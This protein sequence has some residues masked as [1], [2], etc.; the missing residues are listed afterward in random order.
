LEKIEKAKKAGFTRWFLSYT[1]TQKDVEQFRELVGPDAEVVLKIE[2]LKGIH[3]ALF[4][5][6]KD[7]RT[8]LMAAMGDLYVEVTQPHH[9]LPAL[10]AIIAADPEAGVGSRMLLSMSD[11]PVPACADFMQLAWLYEI[12]YRKMMLCDDICLR[13]EF[14]ES[15]IAAFDAFRNN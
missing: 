2:N 7:E 15:A 5:F 13:E 14:L 6:K 11:G 4:D 1:E 10:K 8:W 12:G 3:F 9:I